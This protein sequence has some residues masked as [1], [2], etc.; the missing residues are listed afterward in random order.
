MFAFGGDFPR[1]QYLPHQYGNNYIVYTGTHDNNTLRGWL[2]NEVNDQEK[3]NIRQYLG[4]D[5][6]N[7]MIHWEFIRFAMMSVANIAIFSVTGSFG[8][9]S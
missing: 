3:E 6:H 9:R 5:V 1:S 8:V 4:C 7:P 2:D